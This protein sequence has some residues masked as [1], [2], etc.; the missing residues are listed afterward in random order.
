MRR[1]S[2]IALFAAFAACVVLLQGDAEGQAAFAYPEARHGA[3]VLRQIGGLPVLTAQGT[4]EEVGE[5]IGVLAARPGC[6]VTS[7]PRDLLRFFRAEW[8]F[9]ALLAAGRGM[10]PRF[11][12]HHRTE[13][14]AIARHGGLDPD[15][16][17]AGNT[18]FDIKKMVACSSILVEPGRSATG[19]ILFG[20]NL[21][22]PTMG[23]LHHYTLVTVYK[24][25]G[26]RTFASIGFPGM[27]GVLSGMNDAG[28]CLA[29][30]EAYVGGDES[31]TFDKKGMPFALAMRRLLEECSTI[32]EAAAFLRTLPRTTHLNVPMAD[33]RHA[34]VLEVTSK[35]V[36]VRKAAE[37]LCL[38][39]NHFLTPALQVKGQRNS[40]ETLDRMRRLEERQKL[41]KLGVADVQEALHAA[42]LAQ[43]T[44]QTMV[45]APQSRTLWL[46]YGRCPSS[47]EPLRKLELAELFAAPADRP[48]K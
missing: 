32:D 15:L 26:K 11:P 22:F 36:E 21:D 30:H 20:R 7:Y 35:N 33:A 28:L 24:Q 42:N 4:P 44:L 41:A 39:T 27:V 47:A 14:D 45:F 8:S 17:L 18:F 25:P 9:N 43:H 31:P 23:Y 37:G 10:L 5:Q 48:A 16:V 46:A 29:V 34:A 12:A 38:C 2:A 40:Y 6:R 13:M 19:E 1:L 3:G